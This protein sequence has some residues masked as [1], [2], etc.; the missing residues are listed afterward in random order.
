MG[1]EIFVLRD[2]IMDDEIEKLVIE[3]KFEGSLRSL[4]NLGG[5]SE[6]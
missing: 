4:A 1:E 2:S 3:K 6:K 5:N